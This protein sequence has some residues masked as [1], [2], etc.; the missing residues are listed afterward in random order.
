MLLGQTLSHEGLRQPRPYFKSKAWERR[1]NEKRKEDGRTEL[2]AEGRH[3]EVPSE[4]L[5]VEALLRKVNQD[6]VPL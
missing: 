1:E 3:G 4:P 6:Q 2:R 5:E